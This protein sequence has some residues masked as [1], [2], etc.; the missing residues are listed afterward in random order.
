[1][2]RDG[3]NHRDC[4]WPLTGAE[5]AGVRGLMAIFM[6]FIAVFAV[7]A[8]TT[9]PGRQA[10]W[11]DVEGAIGPATTDYVDRVLEYAAQERAE[12][13]ILRMDT[14][15]GLDTA[16]RGI[17]QSILASSVPVVTYVSPSGARAASAGTYILY[18]SHVAAMAPATTLG[19]AT[20]VQI[21]GMPSVPEPQGEPGKQEQKPL[22]N[23]DAMTRK[24]VNDAAAYIRGLA[25]L[26][27]RNAEWAERA[28]REAA[29][30]TAEQALGMHVIDLV[31]ADM[32]QLLVQLHGRK[33]NALGQERVLDTQGLLLTHR[34]ADWRSK[35][36][37]VITNPNVAYILMLIGIYGLIFEF[38][39]PGA[40]L[41]GIA[42]A[43]CLLLA[44]YAF[45]V[46]PV[47]YTGLAL[48]LLGVALMVAEAIAPSFG[49]LGIGGVVAFVAGSIIL[50][51][52]DVPGFGVSLP[53]IGAF[54][55]FSSALF[56]VV[57]FL[58]FRARR[59]PVVSG[60]E[61]MLGATGIVAADFETDGTVRIHSENWRARSNVPV[62]R[63]QRV[64]V[65]KIDGLTL[66]VEPIAGNSNKEV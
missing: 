10:V 48:I 5:R 44:L 12:L 16:M 31:A 51:D 2:G 27:G 20:P 29:S 47:N 46:L 56:T 33:V 39:N 66:W 14:P 11:M 63:G 36:L 54:A 18:A 59:R 58:V 50:M 28:V 35:L 30:L 8:A 43:I 53:L 60:Q 19:A 34:E 3:K 6:T 42:G 65:K 62:R 55:L 9:A 7:H 21:G 64:C 45:Q 22:E 23:N 17:I 41:P 25:E 38:S 1:M 57:M 37:A 52:T 40:F 61:E 49:A 24:M 15:G 32:S 26:R 4:A 13:V